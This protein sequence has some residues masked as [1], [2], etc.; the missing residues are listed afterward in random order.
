MRTIC[1]TNQFRN[2][3]R[4]TEW[5]SNYPQSLREEEFIWLVLIRKRRIWWSSLW[6]HHY[7]DTRLPQQANLTLLRRWK[8]HN[9]LKVLNPTLEENPRLEPVCTFSSRSKRT[10]GILINNRLLFQ[11]QCS[12]I[13]N[14]KSSNRRLFPQLQRRLRLTRRTWKT[15]LSTLW[16]K[17]RSRRRDLLHRARNLHHD[18]NSSSLI[19]N[20][21]NSSNSNSR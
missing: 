21:N 17:I 3:S 11:T 4:T 6:I 15:T 9:K 14:L 13:R 20:R 1:A 8:I 5:R 7:G 12:T 19:L 18:N 2:R 10:W 16:C